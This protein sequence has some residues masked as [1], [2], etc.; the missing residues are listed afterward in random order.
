MKKIDWTKRLLFYNHRF[1]TNYL[2]TKIMLKNG[3]KRFGSI[4]K[5]SS[6]LFISE[7]T[8]RQKLMKENIQ[9]NPPIRPRELRS[10]K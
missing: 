2:S 4:K 10:K 3:Y 7:E 6:K 8:L 1:N 5:F 9:I